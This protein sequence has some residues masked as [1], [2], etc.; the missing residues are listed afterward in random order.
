MDAFF[1]AM[2]LSVK[3]GQWN[4]LALSTFFPFRPEKRSEFE[5]G[6]HNDWHINIAQF[7]RINIAQTVN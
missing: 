2:F 6:Y 1:I 4:S 3:Y 5:M 7:Y